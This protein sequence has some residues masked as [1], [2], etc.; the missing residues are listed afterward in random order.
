MAVSL[1][2]VYVDVCWL[3][4]VASHLILTRNLSEVLKGRN[5][6]VTDIANAYLKEHG[7]FAISAFT[8][9][10]VVRGFRWQKATAKLAAF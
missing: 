9:F 6:A 4:P 10:E 8:H 5:Q 3:A 7:E 1:R 2:C